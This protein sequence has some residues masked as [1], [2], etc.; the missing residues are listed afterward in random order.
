MLAKINQALE[1]ENLTYQGKI[2][3]RHLLD[4][5]AND[6]GPEKIAAHVKRPLTG[7]KVAPYYGCQ[8]VRPYATYDDNQ[9]P[10][11]MVGIL[12]A[13]G[14]TV[15]HHSHEA[16]CCG[17]ALLTTKPQLGLRSSGR[18][19]RR[20]RSRLP[21]RR[22]PDVPHEPGQL[23]GQGFH[24]AGQA[25]QDSGAIPAAIDRPGVWIAGRATCCSSVKSCR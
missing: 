5:L 3:V 14:A 22:L 9:T 6:F 11:S 19:R 15:H 18:Y 24:G 16:T 7:L 12:E 2:T 13:L 4:M 21:R 20:Q 1:V 17:T 8:T 10:T 25:D 23:P